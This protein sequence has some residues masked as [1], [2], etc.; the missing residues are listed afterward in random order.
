MNRKDDIRAALEYE[1]ET[2]P[3]ETGIKQFCEAFA[4]MIEWRN[5]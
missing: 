2:E 1:V 4:A 5:R 3:P